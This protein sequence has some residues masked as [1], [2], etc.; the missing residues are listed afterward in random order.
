M[1]FEFVHSDELQIH[2]DELQIHS[3]LVICRFKKSEIFMVQMEILLL[4]TLD[5]AL[6]KQGIYY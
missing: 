4:Q 2:S 3:F 6:G 1:S 5:P